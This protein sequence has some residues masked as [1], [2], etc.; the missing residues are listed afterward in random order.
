VGWTKV[1][2]EPGETKQVSVTVDPTATSRSLSYWNVTTNGWQIANGDSQV[3]V[4]A[5]S[6]DI[7]LTGHLSIKH[8]EG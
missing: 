3:F 8:A 5:S 7:R 6:R 2:L 1:D 4:G